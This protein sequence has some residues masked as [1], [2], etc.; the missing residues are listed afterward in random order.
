MVMVASD[1]IQICIEGRWTNGHPVCNVLHYRMD[2]DI[3]NFDIGVEV[4]DVVQNW[5]SQLMGGFRNNYTLEGASWM[6]LRAADGATGFVP[7]NSGEITVG[8]SSGPSTQPGSCLLV[9]KRTASARGSR[10]GRMYLPPP[11]ED[12]VDEDGRIA[13]GLVTALN[14]D[15]ANF[16]ANT[17][18]DAANPGNEINRYMVVLHQDGTS[19]KVNVLQVDGLIA[20]QRRRVR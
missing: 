11:G 6:D 12:D 5:Q 2:D 10:S 18:Q 14:T 13:P 17:T 8:G 3:G 15:L 4:E 9:H 20:S 16:L 1:V 7:P 19:D